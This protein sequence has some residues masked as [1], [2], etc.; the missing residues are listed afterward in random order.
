VPREQ[1]VSRRE[2]FT[3]N[4]TAPDEAILKLS[5]EGMG[6]KESIVHC[7]RTEMKP[8]HPSPFKL[9][10][11]ALP[12]ILG[13]PK[14]PVVVHAPTG[15]GKTAAFTL[16]I[17]QACPTRAGPSPGDAPVALVLTQN[18]SL[19]R[20]H[21]ENMLL[22]GRGTLDKYSNGQPVPPELQV[23]I[24]VGDEGGKGGGGKG[25]KGGGKGGGGGGSGKQE[26][27]RLSATAQVVAGTVGKLVGALKNGA[28]GGRGVSID[29]RKVQVVVFDEVDAMF[30]KG[31]DDVKAILQFCPNARALFVSATIS[32]KAEGI[33]KNDVLG[34]GGGGKGGGGGPLLVIRTN[35][36]TRPAFQAD[37]QLMKHESK[38]ETMRR[39]GEQVQRT[40]KKIVFCA[41]VANVENVAA[42]YRAPLSEG[43]LGLAGTIGVHANSH[44]HDP[45]V[46][47]QEVNPATGKP[48][49]PHECRQQ[50][51]EAFK[52]DES[53]ARDV[54]VCTDDLSRGINIETVQTVVNL[55]LPLDRGQQGQGRQQQTKV[56]ATTYIHRLG[57]AT[58]SET[59]HGLCINVVGGSEEFA[60]DSSGP[61]GH[62]LAE[63]QQLASSGLNPQLAAFG[64]HYVV[65]RDIYREGTADAPLEMEVK[66]AVEAANQKDGQAEAAGA[67]G[68]TAEAWKLLPVTVNKQGEDIE[69]WTV[70]F[71]WP[72]GNS[73]K[74]V[75]LTHDNVHA[76]FDF[77]ALDEEMALFGSKA[78]VETKLVAMIR[79]NSY[80]DLAD[81]LVVLAGVVADLGTAP[82]EGTQSVIQAAWPW[83]E[84]AIQFLV[85]LGKEAT[86]EA[87]KANAA[88]AQRA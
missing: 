84:K 80:A 66:V 77:L 42:K 62:L 49:Q 64:P 20:Q 7:L 87:N 48:F 5:W 17:L 25:G 82:A 72:A 8:L 54:C 52:T 68:G 50:D 11:L 9:H 85:R 16:P 51:L 61:S 47:N 75:P 29:G 86:Y 74:D 24:L 4:G 46:S 73:I 55:D 69:G 56:D 67:G 32:E 58:R 13:N 6:L 81:T 65:P 53:G 26:Q 43:G 88:I 71:E 19:A 70:N 3:V 34:G 39:V 37:F 36:K 44:F 57:R 35:Q 45:R 18:R 14:S 60:P 10:E 38:V 23:G 83:R 2:T 33:I 40:G 22:Y 15:H 59:A 78:D 30:E 41:R 28:G 21:R 31:A 76:P 12:L 63:L 79:T 27:D 1:W